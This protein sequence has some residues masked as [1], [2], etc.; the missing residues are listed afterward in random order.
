[1]KRYII[2]LAGQ[3]SNL[4]SPRSVKV[5]ADNPYDALEAAARRVGVTPQDFPGVEED[6]YFNVH[7]KN[8]EDH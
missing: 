6:V 4:H 5:D 1:V 2:Y 3:P 7:G 8:R